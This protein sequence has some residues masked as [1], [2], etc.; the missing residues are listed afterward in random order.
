MTDHS[1]SIDRDGGPITQA[2]IDDGSFEIDGANDLLAYLDR[3]G[4]GEALIRGM[5]PAV[6][7]DWAVPKGSDANTRLLWRGGA[8]SAVPSVETVYY[9]VTRRQDYLALWAALTAAFGAGGTPY[10]GSEGIVR[11]NGYFDVTAGVWPANQSAPYVWIIAPTWTR[12]I[13]NFV[14]SHRRDGLPFVS[15]GA[16]AAV[17]TL[18]ALTIDGVSYDTISQQLPGEER[19]QGGSRL[20]NYVS[21]QYT[22]PVPTNVEQGNLA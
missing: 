21:A 20:S 18:S 5:P 13:E 6:L 14:W 10:E 3:D 9:A 2:S 16:P 1:V 4:E 12:A 11:G 7:R 15:W 22:S 8:W 17:R 19:A